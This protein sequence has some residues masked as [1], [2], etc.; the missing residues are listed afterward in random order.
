MFNI[1]EKGENFY[2]FLKAT[3]LHAL[4]HEMSKPRPLGYLQWYP[5]FFL[6][7]PFFILSP[8]R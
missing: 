8:P 4:T 5:Y 2:C 1:H 6:S 7:D 3:H